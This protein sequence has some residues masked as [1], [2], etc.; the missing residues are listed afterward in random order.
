MVFQGS[1]RIRS[2]AGWSAKHFTCYNSLNEQGNHRVRG[3]NQD[4]GE[5]RWHAMWGEVDI[6]SLTEMV[7]WR[8]VPKRFWVI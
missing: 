1:G 2:Q 8:I 5:V 4:Q 7:A 6:L 3:E